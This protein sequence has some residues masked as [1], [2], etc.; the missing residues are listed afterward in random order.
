MKFK[1][2]PFYDP[3]AVLL[4]PA[5]LGLLIHFFGSAVVL[6]V[7]VNRTQEFFSSTYGSEKYLAKE[8]SDHC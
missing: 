2:L 8:K 3:I 4:E 7:L 6:H 5:T 1:P